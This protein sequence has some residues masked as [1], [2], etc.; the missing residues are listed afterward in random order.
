MKATFYWGRFL[1]IAVFQKLKLP[2]IQFHNKRVRQIRTKFEC[3]L[4]HES[5][6][7]SN[8]LIELAHLEIL[9]CLLEFNNRRLKKGQLFGNKLIR[10]IGI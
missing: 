7:L 9:D 1:W 8:C 6:P 5:V 3:L 2:R 4:L 10:A